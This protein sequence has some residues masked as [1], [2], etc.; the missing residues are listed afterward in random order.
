MRADCSI[1]ILL[2]NYTTI[3]LYYYY[4]Y[5]YYFAHRYY[6]AVRKAYRQEKR[7]SEYQAGPFPTAT[8][9]AQV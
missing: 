9:S 3:Q 2:Y 5:Y 8:A 6:S 7:D 4:Y 1:T